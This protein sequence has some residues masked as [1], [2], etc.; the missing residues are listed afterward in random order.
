M[1][2]T[3][4]T[5]T[6]TVPFQ[7]DI[8]RIGRQTNQKTLPT[9]TNGYFDSKVLSRQ[10]AEVW[11]ER[12]GKVFI[13]DVKSSN[14][15]FVNGQRLSS[16]NRE[17]EPHELRAEDLLELGIDIVSEDQKTVV[18]HK[19]AARVGY[20]GIHNLSNSVLDLNFGDLD[21]STSGGMMAPPLNQQSIA[22]LRRNGGQGPVNGNG[23]AGSA[24]GSI[25]GSNPS[26]MTRPQYNAAW[27]T[28][29]TMEQI[30]K[31]L[32]AELKQA[33]QQGQTLIQ[34]RQYI[35]TVLSS[36]PKKVEDK[37]VVEKVQKHSPTKPKSTC[38]AQFFEPPAPPPQQ[39]LPEKP[40]AAKALPDAALQPMLRRSD[41]AKPHP[42]A[43]P[44]ARGDSSHQIT[45]LLEELTTARK[46]IDSQ[47]SKVRDLEEMLEKERLARESAEEKA[48]RLEIESRK[49]PIATGHR[50]GSIDSIA[51]LR[52]DLS[53][54]DEQ[55][56]TPSHLI[57]VDDSK[58]ELQQK[59]E[60]MKAEME[61]MKQLMETYRRR[62][63][64]AEDERSTLATMVE[65]IRK[66]NAD[67]DARATSRSRRR[68]IADKVLTTDR[69]AENGTAVM[70]KDDGASFVRRAGIQDG[71]PITTE[72]L[73]QLERDVAKALAANH[74]TRDVL[75]QSGPY[76][77]AI[78][79]VILGVAM[80][81]W[82][83]GWPKV[84]R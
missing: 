41:T 9:P 60:R 52:P 54:T 40:D 17:S 53:D 38:K 66:D 80:M 42:G 29:V 31:K 46:E 6:I 10:H 1:N 51:T 61:E 65:K 19:V 33:Q 71:R 23:R 79:V 58:S 36:E 35:D 5:K 14:G 67:R 47:S 76:A 8:L 64:T 7:P 16:E 56:S 72:Q 32:N 63:E 30:M 13:K 55:K 50:R 69:A 70:T 77:S 25:A 26:V 28:P 78:A 68:S 2:G 34:A 48:Q 82:L 45:R 12:N 39:P 24:Q 73:A 3:F 59:I 22:Q 75:V 11:A 43:S 83:N 20:A 21:P 15:T 37:S 18:H 44:S 74:R 81:N 62:A 84:E 57:A 49:E 27:L 4:D